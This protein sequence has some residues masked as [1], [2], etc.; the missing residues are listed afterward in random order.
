MGGQRRPKG[1]EGRPK[2]GRREAA[3][4]PQGS[5][6]EAEE[7]KSTHS[8]VNPSNKSTLNPYCVFSV[9]YG[10][11]LIVL[12]DLFEFQNVFIFFVFVGWVGSC[13][14]SAVFGF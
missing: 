8:S 3:G 6:R 2:G 1:A 14:C 12:I 4:R 13:V 11:V 7:P 5:R 10:V 9:V